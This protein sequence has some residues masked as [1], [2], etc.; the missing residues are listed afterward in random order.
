MATRRL[1]SQRRRGLARRVS[2][3]SRF[4]RV[5]L[6]I[7]GSDVGQGLELLQDVKHI[8]V[9]RRIGPG[10]PLPRAQA[11]TRVGN[12]VLGNQPLFPQIEQVNGPGVAVTVCFRSLK[13]AVGRADIDA[14]EH[15][16]RSLKYLVMQTDPDGREIDVVVDGPSPLYGPLMKL[17][18]VP[19]SRIC[20]V[21]HA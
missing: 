21:C 11:S 2:S 1:S 5:P 7:R 14:D 17:W 18:T 13:T 19:R 3:S 4:E 6:A 10:S 20:P 12:G 16:L 8:A 15:E 9:T